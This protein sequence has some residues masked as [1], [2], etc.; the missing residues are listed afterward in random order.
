M[1][2][3]AT[4]YFKISL[5]VIVNIWICLSVRQCK[6][7]TM[8]YH[9]LLPWSICG[10]GWINS[11]ST[12]E[13]SPPPQTIAVSNQEPWGPCCSVMNK[14]IKVSWS[15]DTVM[16]CSEAFR[17]EEKLRWISDEPQAGKVGTQMFGK[18]Q[19]ATYFLVFL[20]YSFAIRQIKG[21]IDIIRT[22]SR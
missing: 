9:D 2:L 22:L 14:P 7:S 12:T 3:L 5:F 8:Y 6:M 16:T 15:T 10:M 17:K 19:E 13:A 20:F 11:Y 1:S 18:E 4:F 21:K